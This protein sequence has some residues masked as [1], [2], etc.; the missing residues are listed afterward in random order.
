VLCACS[1]APIICFSRA[2]A[3]K[4]LLRRHHGRQV[5]AWLPRPASLMSLPPYR[6]SDAVFPLAGAP[7]PPHP[8]HEFQ[9][10]G[11]IRS[12]AVASAATQAR[13]RRAGPRVKEFLAL[14]GLP[15]EGVYLTRVHNT[16]PLR[17]KI[18]KN[19]EENKL[20]TK[21]FFPNF[22]QSKRCRRCKVHGGFQCPDEATSRLRRHAPFCAGQPASR[23]SI[24]LD[25][26]RGRCDRR[27]DLAQAPQRA[28]A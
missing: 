13:G 2:T 22:E 28:E 1:P 10:N 6:R 24:L 4:S 9:G 26:G 8:S 20:Y 19:P 18:L 23:S 14:A 16:C 12:D 25:Q 17:A 21:K 3:L 15:G 7:A 5:T 11:P 27:P